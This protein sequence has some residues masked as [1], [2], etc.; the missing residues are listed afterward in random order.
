MSTLWA[1]DLK[2]EYETGRKAVT[3]YKN[4]LDR[5]DPSNENYLT[6]ANSMIA[7]SKESEEWLMTG[8]DPRAYKGIDKKSIYH[9]NSWD[10]MDLIPDI[11][12]ELESDGPPELSLSVDSKEKLSRI[13]SALSPRERQCY[14]LHNAQRLSM[15][16]I[17]IELEVSKSTV[18][19]YLKRA[20]VKVE[21]RA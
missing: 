4:N 16:Q 18:Q 8:R 3:Q 15:A 11:R 7:G 19:M 21:L 13:F 12:D 5:D 9:R 2:C 14:I 17:A 1:D 20:K 10:A 6:L